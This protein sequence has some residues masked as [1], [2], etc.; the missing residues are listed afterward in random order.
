LECG[1]CIQAKAVQSVQQVT[2]LAPMKDR[3]LAVEGN[4]IPVFADRHLR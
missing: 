2:D 4:L 3:F 1:I